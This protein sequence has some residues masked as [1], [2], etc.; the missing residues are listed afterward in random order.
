MFDV[1][2]KPSCITYYGGRLWIATHNIL[3]KSKMVAYYYDKKDDR[4]TSLNTYTIPARVQGVTF[5]TSGKV[6]LST[7]YG[8]NESSYIKCYKSLIAL[9]SRPNRPDITIEMPP[10]SEELASVDKRLYVIFES[11]GEKYLEGTDGKGNS[12]API[13]KILRINTDSFKN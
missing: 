10:G 13:D 4:L 6:Y 9:S 11:A 7:S 3:F 1:G 8:R 5:D 12:P 2:N